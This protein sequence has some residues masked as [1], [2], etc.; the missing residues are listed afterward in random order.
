MPGILLDRHEP[1]SLIPGLSPDECRDLTARGIIDRGMI[2]KVEACLSSLESGVLK[3]HII[4]GR[5]PHALLLE[6]FTKTGIGTEIVR[7][8]SANNAPATGRRAVMARS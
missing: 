6:I 5:L 1:D 7:P 4:D 8:D 2:P 3:T